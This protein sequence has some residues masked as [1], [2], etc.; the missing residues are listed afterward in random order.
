MIDFNMF[1]VFCL[2]GLYEDF[3]EFE[4]HVSLVIVCLYLLLIPINSSNSMASSFM[5][6]RCIFIKSVFLLIG[7]VSNCIHIVGSSS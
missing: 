5:V 4:T 7:L 6:L 2:Q 1:S 3:I